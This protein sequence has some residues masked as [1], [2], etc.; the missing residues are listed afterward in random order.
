MNR[1]FRNAFLNTGF[2]SFVFSRRRIDHLEYDVMMT[3]QTVY[4]VIWL[5][6][7]LFKYTHV[8]DAVTEVRIHLNKK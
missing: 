1:V 7:F 5:I 3:K 2:Q 8:R 6:H 4:T